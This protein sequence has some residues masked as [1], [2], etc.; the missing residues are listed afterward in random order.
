MAPCRHTPPALLVTAAALLLCLL[1]ACSQAPQQLTALL[2]VQGEGSL[3]DIV[4]TLTL[5]QIPA[6]VTLDQD[7][8]WDESLLLHHVNSAGQLAPPVAGAYRVKGST[9]ELTPS[10]SLLAGHDYVGRFDASA[11]PGLEALTEPIEIRFRTGDD[12]VERSV[13]SVLAIHPDIDTLPANHLKFYILFSEPMLQGEIFEFFSLLDKTTGKAV[14]RP[15]RHTELWSSDDRRLTLWFHPGRQKTGVN[16]NVELGAILEQGHRYELN[17]DPAW[18][19]RH[20]VPLGKQVVKSFQAGPADRQQ[21]DPDSWQLALPAEGSRAPLLCNMRETLDWA[22]AQRVIQVVGPMP[23]TS[24]LDGIVELADDDRVWSFTPTR[25]WR[26]GRYRLAIGS[27]LEDLAGNS[28]ARPF[29]L[30]IRSVGEE[31][32]RPEDIHMLEFAIPGAGAQP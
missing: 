2:E 23:S 19:S 24:P 29:E 7:Q 1:P 14:P 8:P 30:D 26:A 16:L 11:I 10:F 4:I 3:D 13:P 21:P 5:A 22:L 25:P 32:A 20:G 15:F 17:I 31:D 9:V 6:G 18:T 12:P 27:I 28:V